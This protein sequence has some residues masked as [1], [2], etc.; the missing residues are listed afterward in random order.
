MADS[1]TGRRLADKAE[2]AQREG[3]VPLGLR[4]RRASAFRMRSL[5]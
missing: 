3:E 5:E 4:A 1:A 2:R